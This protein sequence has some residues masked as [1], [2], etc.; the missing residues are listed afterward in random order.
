MGL[1]NCEREGQFRFNSFR[2]LLEEEVNVAGKR[3]VD[4][5][6]GPC[7]FARI[8]AEFG[9]HVTAVDGRDER[10]PDDIS[11]KEAN[12]V[13]GI[14]RLL[15]ARK[16]IRDQ[17]RNRKLQS[18][19]ETKKRNSG[20]ITFVLSDVRDF[21][22]DSFDVV[23]IFGLLYHFGLAEQMKLLNR[24]KGKIVLVDTMVC[25]PDLITHYPQY[26]WQSSTHKEGAYEGWIY[27][28]NNN[29]M[30][31]IGNKT[32]F[33]HTDLSYGRLFSDCGFSNIVAYRP[34]YNAKKYGLRSFYRL[35]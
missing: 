25:A 1:G 13:G 22:F 35:S 9:A 7:H 10:I 34:L 11:R 24:C 18:K 19:Q 20:E 16:I 29:P 26:D 3:V 32:S 31:S 14:Q 5:G 33:W 15:S 28:E 6:A 27:P 30:A 21:D 17:N 23:L 8:A 12:T 2:W 4:L